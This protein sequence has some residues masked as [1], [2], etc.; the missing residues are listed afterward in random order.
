MSSFYA[1]ISD[2]IYIIL[3]EFINLGS[4]YLALSSIIDTGCKARPYAIQTGSR[5]TLRRSWLD[6]KTYLK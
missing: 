3:Y 5:S 6:T 1:G 2:P 4:L